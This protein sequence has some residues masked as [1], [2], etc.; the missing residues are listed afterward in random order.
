MKERLCDVNHQWTIN[1]MNYHFDLYTF[2]KIFN[3][4]F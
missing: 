1:L 2:T 3:F 4:D